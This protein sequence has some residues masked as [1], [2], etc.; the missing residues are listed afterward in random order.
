[1]TLQLCKVLYCL[2]RYVNYARINK[3]KI[4][5]QIELYVWTYN[6]FIHWKLCNS[7]KMHNSVQQHA[8]VKYQ[9][10][11]AIMNS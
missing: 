7:V 5:L 11:Y 10:I 1:M 8:A 2:L 3:K 6:D 9:H 4:I